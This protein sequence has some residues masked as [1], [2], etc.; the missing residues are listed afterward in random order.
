MTDKPDYRELSKE[1]GDRDQDSTLNSSDH[2][3][4]RRFLQEDK[5][6]AERKTHE[7]VNK[8]QIP[9]IELDPGRVHYAS[10][11]WKETHWKDGTLRVET[12]DGTGYV[13]KRD[14]AGA[15]TLHGWGPAA[16]DNYTYTKYPDGS[17]RVDE[18]DGSGFTIKA[19]GQAQAWGPAG[20][21]QAAQTSPEHLKVMQLRLSGFDQHLRTIKLLER[22]RGVAERVEDIEKKATD[23]KDNRK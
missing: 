2:A 15:E 13:A 16:N 17:A 3:Q 4:H 20:L 14:A 1:K 18:G 8:G 6:K 22:T 7:M 23:R 21:D 19:D 5:V 9:A 10:D 12:P 11:G